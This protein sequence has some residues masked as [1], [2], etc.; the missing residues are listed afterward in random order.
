MAW[1]GGYELVNW[2]LR[3]SVLYLNVVMMPLFEKQ[4]THGVR[5]RTRSSILIAECDDLPLTLMTT[6]TH[7]R[8]ET[9]SRSSFFDLLNE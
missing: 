4:R 3:V 8:P 5:K 2:I 6:H 1:G 9:T 7:T